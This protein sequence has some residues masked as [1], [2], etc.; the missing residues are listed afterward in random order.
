MEEKNVYLVKDLV[1]CVVVTKQGETLGPLLDVLGTGANDVYV[2]G[3]G[4]SEILIPALKSVVL[5]IDLEN[6]RIEVDLPIGLFR[7]G[8]LAGI[9][10]KK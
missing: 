7:P 6:K 2:V 10:R 4:M 9:S 1:G 5:K 8:S 3:E